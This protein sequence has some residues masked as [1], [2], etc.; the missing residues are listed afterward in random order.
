MIYKIY[1][2]FI[3]ILISSCSFIDS[4]KEATHIIIKEPTPY[5]EVV[6]KKQKPYIKITKVNKNLNQKLSIK[7]QKKIYPNIW[8]EINSNHS[9]FE[10]KTKDLFWHLKWFTDN[11]KYL[12]R[13]TKRAE[14]YIKIVLDEVKK[15]GVPYEIALLPIVESAFYPFAYSHGTASG[16]WQFIP[17]TGK[18]YGLKQNFWIDERRDILKSTRAAIKYLSN[19]NKMF[20]GDWLLAIAAYN[21]GPGRVAKAIKRNKKLGKKTDFWSLKLPKETKGYVP[22]LISVAKLIKYPDKYGQTISKVA[23]KTVM[24]SVKLK[25]QLDLSLVSK[26]S[27]LSIDNIYKLNP[28]LNRW[29]TPPGKYELVLPINKINEFKQKLKAYP[30][31]QRIKWVRHKIKSGESVNSIA[32]KYAIKTRALKKINKLKSNKIIIGKYLI[33]PA[34]SKDLAYY[35]MSQNQ[36]ENKRLKKDNAIKTIHK[37]KEGGSLWDISRKYKVSVNKLIKWN[38]LNSRKIINI[39]DK[40]VI[41]Q[42]K[43]IRNKKI[44]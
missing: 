40:L 1:L 20:D 36:L 16:M 27:N 19:L 12:T 43:T 11:P 13:I 44:S 38:F 5:I 26:W 34:A 14:P 8:N 24:G 33:I 9:L 4:T 41:W 28:G 32:K 31:N 2:I 29:A 7:I 42:K 3:V 15:Q 17:S 30:K 22:R 21:S 35:S 10:Y 25:S 37:V 6:K 23:N 39:G 18:L